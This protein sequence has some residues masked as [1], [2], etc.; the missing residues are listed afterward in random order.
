MLTTSGNFSFIRLNFADTQ[1]WGRDLLLYVKYCYKWR[2]ILV[3]LAFSPS[4]KCN[5][6]C[7]IESIQ[8]TFYDQFAKHICYLIWNI[9][10]L[11]IILILRLICSITVL[12]SFMSIK[13]FSILA[14]EVVFAC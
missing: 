12:N 8:L 13:V 6:I 5:H 2:T 3:F 1:G 10:C 11:A 14:V 7:T 4:D 9:L